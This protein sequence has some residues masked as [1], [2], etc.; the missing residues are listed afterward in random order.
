MPT[1]PQ[2]LRELLAK[3]LAD[4]GDH[5]IATGDDL[6]WLTAQLAC[7]PTRVGEDCTTNDRFLRLSGAA[8]LQ[9]QDSLIQELVGA[10][11]RAHEWIAEDDCAGF[12]PA[13]RA[14]RGKVLRQVSSALESARKAHTAAE[15]ER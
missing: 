11:E 14:C 5:M 3:A 7:W 8:T 13:E 15:G 12:G 10:L 6:A 2:R 9:S 1:K 4:D